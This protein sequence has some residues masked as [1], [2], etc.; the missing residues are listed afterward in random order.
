[1]LCCG[2]FCLFIILDE[3][4]NVLDIMPITVALGFCFS[5]WLCVR[6][7]V[8]VRVCCHPRAPFNALSTDP[9]AAAAAVVTA[10]VQV[11]SCDVKG[12]PRQFERE[13]L[14]SKVA[15]VSDVA[16]QLSE[17]NKVTPQVCAFA[18]TACM[19]VPPPASR[20]G[21]RPPRSKRRELADPSV[22]LGVSRDKDMAGCSPNSV[23]RQT[24]SRYKSLGCS[25]LEHPGFSTFFC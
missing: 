17:A 6:E 7:R 23:D 1:M 13:M 11:A 2:A 15:K 8:V 21:G 14:F 16:K 25:F 24:R 5:E 10:G 19:V 12:K 22:F 9:P 20:R 3:A 18:S 4:V